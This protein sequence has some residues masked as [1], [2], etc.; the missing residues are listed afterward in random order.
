V[1]LARRSQRVTRLL[2]T[3]LVMLSLV[4]ITLDYREGATGPFE[5]MGRALF[6][7]VAPMQD[8]V[9]HVFR[10][11]G[12]FFSGLA[13][14]G[15]LESENR[16]LRAQVKDLQTRNGQVVTLQQ[17]LQAAEALIQIKERLNLT[18]SIGANVIASSVSN[19][20]WTI[21][22]DRGSSDGVQV[23]DPVV[24]SAG[25]VGRVIGPI[26]S[27]CA[28]VRLIIDPKSAVAARLAATGE[29]GLI[30]GQRNEPLQMQLV[31]AEAEVPAGEEVVTSGYQGGLFPPGIPVGTVS[32]V[33]DDP[34]SLSKVIQIR[35]SVDFS[36]LE[37]VLVV[38][39]PG[40]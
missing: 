32:H 19:F 35:P 38:L 33:Y 10:P 14:V 17:Q 34:G 6:S 31:S 21:T 26:A 24:A 16:R 13:H 5:T 1:A 4:T 8:A 27:C 18:N 29:T 30:V 7:V 25:L 2:V 9:S 36:S 39:G 22:V 15:S 23:N 40:S 20:Q 28:T 37:F 11:I 12:S 3:S